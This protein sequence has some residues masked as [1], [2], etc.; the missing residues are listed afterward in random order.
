MVEHV[1]GAGG[2]KRQLSASAKTA[3]TFYGL[4]MASEV[5]TVPAR[6]SRETPAS[7]RNPTHH[8][9]VHPLAPSEWPQGE[10]GFLRELFKED[11]EELHELSTELDQRRSEL[12]RF[13]RL[14]VLLL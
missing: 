3:N 6:N 10:Q 9:H 4:V 11:I 12:N 14:L 8:P 13:E 5:A 7:A 2:C 1:P